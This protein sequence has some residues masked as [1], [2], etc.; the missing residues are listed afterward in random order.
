METAMNRLCRIEKCFCL[1]TAL[2]NICSK[3]VLQAGDKGGG[4][5]GTT[6]QQRESG[7][8]AAQNS[9]EREVVMGGKNMNKTR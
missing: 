6:Q 1:C 8:T 7:Q 2:E 5:G 3:K 9:D 4:K